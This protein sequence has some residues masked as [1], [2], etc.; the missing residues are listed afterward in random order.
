MITSVSTKGMTQ[1]QWLASRRNAVGGS[2]AAAIIGLNAHSSPYTVWLDK[3]GRIQPKEETEAMR[4]GHD[5]EE[6]V[7]R[8][9]TEATGKRVRRRNAIL[10]NDAY[11][12]AHANVDRE[13]IGEN[14][15]LECKTTNVLNLHKFKGGS[16]PANYYV[17]VVHYMAVTGAKKAYI[18]VLVLGQGFYWFEVMRD[19]DEI[20]ALMNAEREFW[21]HVTDETEPPL[22]GIDADI[23]AFTGQHPQSNGQSIQLFGRESTMRRYLEI[24]EQ[25]KSLEKQGEQLAAVIKQE[26]GDN[27]QGVDGEHT[28][29][30]KTQT[31]TFFDK[32]AF[33]EAHPDI[34]LGAFQRTTTYRV[35][36]VK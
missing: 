25:I 33:V 20:V 16:Y 14:A 23:D 18:A 34:N 10:Y 28:A 6:Y 22:T 32:E 13:V 2:D 31:R 9:F 12:F 7:A 1:Q 15:I 8:R 19:E 27:E 5:L 4:I 21:N 36:A 24:K 35:F 29:T 11:P 3:L 30:W 26:L 17:Q